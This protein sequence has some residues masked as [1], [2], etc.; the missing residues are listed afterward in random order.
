MKVRDAATRCLAVTTI[1]CFVVVVV[2]VAVVFLKI[3]TDI[4]S[5]LKRY[6][7]DVTRERKL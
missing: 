6:R 5:R 3:A 4:H 2:V 7:K 1:L